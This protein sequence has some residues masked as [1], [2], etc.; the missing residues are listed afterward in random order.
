ME[1]SDSSKQK[2]KQVERASLPLGVRK[3]TQFEIFRVNIV[4]YLVKLL[5]NEKFSLQIKFSE[6]SLETREWRASTVTPEA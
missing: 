3:I 2:A 1:K 4:K 5:R 6:M